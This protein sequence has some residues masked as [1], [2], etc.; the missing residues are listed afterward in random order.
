MN[1]F[2]TLEITF[3]IINFCM[4]NLNFTAMEGFSHI[5]GGQISTRVRSLH[6]CLLQ[7]GWQNFRDR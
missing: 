7:T 1:N 6:A 2:I 4:L 5:V 3:N